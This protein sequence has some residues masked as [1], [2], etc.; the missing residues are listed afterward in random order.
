MHGSETASEATRSLRVLELF[1]GIGGCSA[2]MTSPG[3]VVAA[4]DIS[5]AALEVYRWNFQHTTL[6]I[7]LDFVSASALRHWQAD[8]WWLSPPC[9][10]FTTRGLRRDSE[11]PRA[12]SFLRIIDALETAAPTYLA[13]ENVPGFRGSRTHS[14]LRSV[15]DKL[16]YAVEEVVLCPTELGIPNRRQRL[17]IAAG[18]EGL[19]PMVPPP[20]VGRPLADYL[21]PDPSPDLWV[22]EDLIR[23]YRQALNIVDPDEATAVTS[24]F[25]SAYGRSPVRSGSYLWTPSGIRRFSPQEI[26]R[27]L[28]FPPGFTLP[29]DLST[30]VAWR[31]AGNS[32]S[33]PAVRFVLSAIPA[34]RGDRPPYSR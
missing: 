30:G 6:Q 34:L 15:L 29:P 13:L 1:C 31:L 21:D 23:R 7:G 14:R 2:A 4:L 18:L 9:Q 27:L 28:G 8:L 25:T 3:R 33:V 11:D 26:L 20:P 5:G 12:R 17:Y 10:P 22:E 24:C 32:L 19:A 16:G